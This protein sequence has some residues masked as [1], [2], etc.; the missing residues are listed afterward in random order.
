MQINTLSLGKTNTRNIKNLSPFNLISENQIS[1]PVERWEYIN[2]F[3]LNT[4]CCIVKQ[5]STIIIEF[6]N[7]SL[8]SEYYEEELP[9]GNSKTKIAVQQ[10]SQNE[11]MKQQL[12]NASLFSFNFE[13]WYAGLSALKVKTKLGKQYQIL[14]DVCFIPLKSNQITFLR[15]CIKKKLWYVSNYNDEEKEF[16]SQ[17]E[18]KINQMIQLFNQSNQ[19]ENGFFVRMSGHSPK[20]VNKS[21]NVHS[22]EDVMDILL[23]SDRIVIDLEILRKFL[24]CNKYQNIILI[25]WNTKMKTEMEFRCFVYNGNLTA[26]SQYEYTECFEFLQQCENLEIILNSIQLFFNQISNGVRFYSYVFDVFLYKDETDDD[27]FVNLIEL[28][29]FFGDLSSGS[30]LFDW[31]D[32]S[33]IL[34]STSNKTTLRVKKNEKEILEI[35]S[36]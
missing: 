3:L 30:C 36:N 8:P 31:E 18:N 9:F 7:E 10:F 27:W 28:N 23:R 14:P 12:H 15:R 11:L 22:G 1:F 33:N 29:P 5:D 21:L 32:D 34:C 4:S 16:I 35:T 13:E 2:T 17:I 26:I 24:Y 19:Y 20:D 25:P 6:D